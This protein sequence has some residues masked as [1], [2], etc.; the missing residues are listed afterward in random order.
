M[1]SRAWVLKHLMFYAEALGIPQAWKIDVVEDAALGG[2]GRDAEVHYNVQSMYA[3]IHIRPDMEENID[4][5]E[6][7]LHELLH[8]C[9][10]NFSLVLPTEKEES[11]ANALEEQTVTQMARALIRK[12]HHD[13]ESCTESVPSAD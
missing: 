11:V 2:R 4:G 10:A 8:I 7:L 3:E 12:L 6:T 1:A 5:Q 13:H 9:L